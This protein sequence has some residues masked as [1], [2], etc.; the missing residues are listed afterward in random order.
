MIVAVKGSMHIS[1]VK[2]TGNSKFRP[3]EQSIFGRLNKDNTQ[4]PL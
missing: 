2:L 1:L 4:H 3:F